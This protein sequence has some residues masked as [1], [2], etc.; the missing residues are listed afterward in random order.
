MLRVVASHQPPLVF[1]NEAADGT[2][3]FTGFLV[4]L[5]P[6]LLDAAGLPSNYSIFQLP[7]RERQ[8]PDVQLST[9]LMWH[10]TF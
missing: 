1:V 9:T 5:L 8:V 10:V 4:E 3:N 2:T 7:V 6:M